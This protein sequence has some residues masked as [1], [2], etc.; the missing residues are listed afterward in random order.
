MQLNHISQ[1][2]V[3]FRE[4][5]ILSR[6]HIYLSNLLEDR[7]SKGGA[8]LCVSM[9]PRIGKSELTS[10]TMPAWFFSKR[11]QAQVIQISYGSDLASDFGSAVRA[12]MSHPMYS[13]MFPLSTP[14]GEGESGTQWKTRAKGTYK[15]VGIGGSITGFGADLI[16]ID[17]IVKNRQTAHS[18]A[19]KRLIREGFG[20]TIFTRLLPGGSIVVV[21]TRWTNDD[22]IG[23]LTQELEGWEYI[24]LKAIADSFDPLGRECGEA[25]FPEMYPI[26]ALLEIKSTMSSYDWQCLYQGTPPDSTEYL[27]IRETVKGS[28]GTSLVW[29]NN[30]LASYN[31]QGHICSVAEVDTIS[32]LIEYLVN[33]DQD[34]T[35]LVSNNSVANNRLASKILSQYGLTVTYQQQLEGYSTS[36]RPLYIPIEYHSNFQ[37]IGIAQYLDSILVVQQRPHSNRFGPSKFIY[38]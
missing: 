5:Y 33:S 9:P 36:N 7:L 29:F 4:N 30:L 16:I 20:P 18:P 15:G 12:T 17:D 34:F 14:T 24:N 22:L 11:P 13:A 38:R 35:S 32:E 19:S 37:V 8:R 23:M 31:N 28:V 25:L 10:R 2:L 6:V 26:E 21:N 3:A 27:D 1:F